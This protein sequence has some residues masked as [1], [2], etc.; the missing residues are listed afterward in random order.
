MIYENNRMY[1]NQKSPIFLN[2]MKSEH[3]TYANKRFSEKPNEITL[4]NKILHCCRSQTNNTMLN[5]KID[6]NLASNKRLSGLR[7]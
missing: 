7:D 6:L 3:F 2:E 4:K 1:S 5:V